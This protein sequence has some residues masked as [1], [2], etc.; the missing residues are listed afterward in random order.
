[1][2]YIQTWRDFYPSEGTY[3]IFLVQKTTETFNNQKK[4]EWRQ[5]A[6]LSNSLSALKKEEVEPLIKMEKQIVVRKP[7]T[8]F[9]KATPNPRCINNIRINSQFTVS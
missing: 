6:P 7:I 8:Q 2:G 1:M 4:E 5:G 3:R 9:V